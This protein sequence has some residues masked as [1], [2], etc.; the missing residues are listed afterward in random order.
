MERQKRRQAAVGSPGRSKLGTGERGIAL[1]AVLWV[2][3]L[4]SLL[5]TSLTRTTRTG[6]QLAR[7]LVASAE[8]RALADAGIYR[9]IAGLMERQP[10]RR[11]AVDGTRYRIA[12]ARGEVLLSLQDEGGKIDLN[13]APVE[14][15]VS[16]FQTVGVER[17][18][19]VALADAVAD[20]RD[21]DHDRHL[22][23]AEDSEYRR[24]GLSHGAKDAPFEAIEELR[25]VLGVSEALYQELRPAITVF[26]RGR[27]V[28]RATAPPLVLRALP[29]MDQPAMLEQLEAR[30]ARTESTTTL[31]D[32]MAAGDE[33]DEPITARRRRVGRFGGAVTISAE[34]HTADGAV[35]VREAVVRP[36]ARIA[37]RAGVQERPYLI[38]AWRKGQPPAPGAAAAE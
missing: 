4:L 33:T 20:Y 24:A 22:S 26:G 18:A 19:S 13:R 25:N 10:E 37:R 36:S 23:G 14:M 30:E 38:L 12:F 17:E 7:N 9:A 6:S 31:D 34:A 21:G 3:V 15:L 2:M 29:G 32:D 16:L 35:F 27:R 11:L 8:A 28:N 5:A 1:I